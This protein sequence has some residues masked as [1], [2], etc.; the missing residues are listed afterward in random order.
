MRSRDQWIEEGET[1]SNFVLRHEKENRVDRWIATLKDEDGVIHSDVDS[2]SNVLSPFYS[3]NT[4][5]S[6]QIFLLSLLRSLV[7][8]KVCSPFSECHAAL[9]GVALRKPPGYDGLLDEFYLKFW[10]LLG[11]DLVEV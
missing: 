7:C 4:I 5:P 10:N 8:V 1:S 11:V 9:S 3:K 2:I 6:A